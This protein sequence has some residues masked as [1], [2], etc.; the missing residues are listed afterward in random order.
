MFL[1]FLFHEVLTREVHARTFTWLCIVLGLVHTYPDTFE[2]AN[3]S[4]RIQ[5]LLA[6]TR[7]RIQIEFAVHTHPDLLSG[8]GLLCTIL[9]TEHAHMFVWRH[10]CGVVTSSDQKVYG[11]GVHT[12]PNCY[13]I[14]NFFT[15]FIGCVWTIPV[16]GKKSLRIQRYPD[17]CGRGLN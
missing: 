3:F 10:W 17:T 15:D 13:R 8:P 16:S 9:S 1:L 11:Y 14:Q 5:H 6:S 2:S 7:I 12:Y 4:F